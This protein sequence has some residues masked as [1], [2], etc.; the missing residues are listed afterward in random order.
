MPWTC[1]R[2][3]NVLDPLFGFQKRRRAPL[4]AVHCKSKTLDSSGPLLRRLEEKI[5]FCSSIEDFILGSEGE[6]KERLTFRD[7]LFAK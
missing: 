7:S 4:K 2:Q 1:P 5:P 3:S 6:I